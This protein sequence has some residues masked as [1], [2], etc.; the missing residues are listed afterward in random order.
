MAEI[1]RLAPQFF[2]TARGQRLVTNQRFWM[3]LKMERPKKCNSVRGT[4]VH[5]GNLAFLKS[6][7]PFENTGS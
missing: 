3:G 6:F 7:H 4:R 1:F 2:S 5:I